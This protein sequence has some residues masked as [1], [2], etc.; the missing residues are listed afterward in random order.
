MKMWFNNCG[1]RLN[2]KLFLHVLF[3]TGFWWLVSAGSNSTCSSLNVRLYI[4]SRLA[5]SLLKTSFPLVL[6]PLHH[7][8]LPQKNEGDLF[9]RLWHV[10]NE[11]L[12]LRRQV[13]VGH[14][15]HD[16]MKDVKQHIT[17]R[18][19]WGNEW[20]SGRQC[21]STS[22]IE[23]IRVQNQVLARHLFVW[24]LAKPALF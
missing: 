8:H 21:L 14:L 13:L 22:L 19:D 9:H 4:S 7:L 17:A 1:T 12:D 5:V 24:I 15:T 3:Q 20:V 23:A 16:R 6:L 2:E 10:M 11:I 18:L